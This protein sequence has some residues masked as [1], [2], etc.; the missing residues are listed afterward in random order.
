MTQ[1]LT[2]IFDMDG[3]I[4]DTESLVRRCWNELACAHHLADMDAVFLLT[5][6]STDEYT[7]E[8]MRKHYGASFPYEELNAQASRLFH[9]IADTEGIPVKSGVRELLTFLR[10]HHCRIGLASST[11]QVIV[12][13][14]LRQAGLFHYFDTILGGDQISH[15]KPAPDIYIAACQQIGVPPQTAFA[16][17]D[18]YNGIRAAFGA[19]MRPIMVPDLLPPIPEVEALC[20]AILPDLHHVQSYLDDTYNR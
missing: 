17:E 19:G 11:R 10:A 2:V 1:P 16:I 18:S 9:S 13:K 12:E 7:G 5:V 15:S 3:V 6:G 8:I 14:E 4:L 20:H